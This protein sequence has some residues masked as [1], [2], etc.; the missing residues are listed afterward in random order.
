M[1]IATTMNGEKLML[2][3]KVILTLL[4][5]YAVEAKIKKMYNLIAKLANSE[6]VTLPSYEEALAAHEAESKD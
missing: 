2:E 6:G 1:A 5:E 3:T 4:M